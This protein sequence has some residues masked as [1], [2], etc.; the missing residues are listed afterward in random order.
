MKHATRLSICLSALAAVTA[1]TGAQA[2][3]LTQLPLSYAQRPLTLTRHTLRGDVDLTIAH[4]QVSVLGTTASS[5][6]VGLALGAGFGITEDLEVGATVIPL[7]LSP[8]FQYNAPSLYG[9]YR[10]VRG[11]VD[12]GARLTLIMPV[13]RDFGLNVGV[14]VLFHL[15][16][17]ARLD[18]GAFLSLNFGDPLGK[19]LS[20]PVAFTANLNPNL[21]LGARTGFILPEFDRLVMPLGVYVGYSIAG[22]GGATPVAD[23]TASFDFP[24]FLATG[25]NDAIVPD[26]WTIGLNGRL[27]FNL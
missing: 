26:L 3:P 7:T 23:I 4:L 24:L 11:T 22:G 18:T 12:V 5:T 10:F 27:Y 9:M 20:I 13:D 16:D 1:A 15:G 8:D 14:P 19:A 21:F 17:N 6:A 2:Q 25:R